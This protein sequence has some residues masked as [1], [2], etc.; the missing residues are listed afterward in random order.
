MGRRRSTARGGTTMRRSVAIAG[1]RASRIHRGEPGARDVRHC[2]ARIGEAHVVP[3][4]GSS[5]ARSPSMFAWTHCPRRTAA[6]FGMSE[7][8]SR[9]VNPATWSSATRTASSNPR[10]SS[11]PGAGSSVPQDA[12]PKSRPA[13]RAPSSPA[14]RRHQH[15][16]DLAEQRDVVP[17]V[18]GRDAER[19]LLGRGAH[20]VILRPGRAE[21]RSRGGA[22]PRPVSV[23]PRRHPRYDGSV[24]PDLLVRVTADPIGADEAVGFVSDPAAGGT[25]VF[26]GTVRDHS[27]AG[28]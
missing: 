23:G 15:P 14:A 28:W 3:T 10:L 21:R 7:G 18:A 26:L 17:D 19:L 6:T 8:A 4:A 9:P 12:K 22:R 27:D 25:C 2:A 5:T 1:P 13:W 16:L 11:S 20:P 24:R